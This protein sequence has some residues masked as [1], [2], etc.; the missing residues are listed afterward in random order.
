MTQPRSKLTKAKRFRVWF[1]SLDSQHQITVFTAIIGLVG[2]LGAASLTAAASLRASARSGN[3]AVAAP[4]SAPAHSRI[5]EGGADIS[6]R[7]GSSAAASGVGPVATGVSSASE[8]SPLGSTFQRGPN[9]VAGIPYEDCLFADLSWS[10]YPTA[11]YNLKRKFIR[12]EGTIGIADD[13]LS[14]GAAEFKITLDGQV[15]YTKTLALGQVAK[16]DVSLR[17][18]YRMTLLSATPGIQSSE[19]R[20]VWADLRFT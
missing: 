7:P 17:N 12:L 18:G 14:G 10:D 6:T 1:K 20:A 16:I 15:V 9:T 11:Y 2:V 19:V 5:E 8:L 4:Q 3:S 13:S